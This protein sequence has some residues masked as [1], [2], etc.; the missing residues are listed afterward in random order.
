LLKLK[1]LELFGFKS[2]CDRQQLQFGGGGVSA[3]VGPNGCGKSNISDSIS[4]V[5][6]ERSAKSLRGARMGD[7]IFNGSRDRKPSGF[8]AVSLTLLDPDG[9]L[10]SADLNGLAHV[11]NGHG[12]NGSSSSL[13]TEI[14]VTR[15]L[16]NSGESI[17]LLNGKTC[18]LRDIQ[19]LFMGTG[20]GPEHYAIIEQGRVGQILGSRPAERR[21]VI[22][23]AAGITKFKTKKRLAE[24]KLE[25]AR[26]NLHRVND[27]LQE[28]IRQVGSLKR[29]AAK[30]RRYEELRKQWTENLALLLAS[31]YREMNR[32]VEEATGEMTRTDEEFRE[33]AARVAELETSA[34]ENRRQEQVHEQSLEQR[35]AELSEVTMEIERLRS[36]VEQQTRTAGETSV[37]THQAEAEVVQLS[38]RMTALEEELVREQAALDSVSGQAA[39]VRRQLA[40]KTAELEQRMASIRSDEQRQEG[41]RHQVLRLLG[42]LSSLKNELAKMDEFLAGNERHL[43]RVQEEA[44]SAEQELSE[45]TRGHG[46]LEGQVEEQQQKLDAL[47]EQRRLTQQE[48]SG[49]KQEAE[50]RR[51][52]AEKLRHDLSRLRARRESLDEILSHHAYTTETVKNLFASIQSR[53]VSGFEP[54]GILADFVEVDSAFE[55]MSEDFLRE[56][57]EFVV[58]K[59]W[60][61]AQQGLQLLYGEIQGCATFLV[62]PESPVPPE[63]AVLGPETGVVGRLSDHIRLTN[64]LS[65]SASTLLPRLRSCYL[66]EEETAAKRLGVQYPDLYFLLPNGQCYHGYTVSGGKKGTAG[67]LALKREL[68]ELTPRLAAMEEQLAEAST[69]AEQDQQQI[70]AST[71]QLESLQAEIQ[72]AE[73]GI[74]GVEHQLRQLKDQTERAQRRLS[75]SQSDMERLRR[76]AEQTTEQ[77]DRNR[78]AINERE[79]QRLAVEESLSQL[80]Q[81]LQQSHTESSL[82]SEEQTRLR[83]EAAALEERHKAAEAS[84]ARVRSQAAELGE[85]RRHILAQIESW[86]AECKRLLA[87]NQ[88]LELRI[89]EQTTRRT[90][91]QE[92]VTQLSGDLQHAREQAAAI[93]EEVKDKR[94]SLETVRERRSAIELALVELR[95]DV[96]HL[97]ETCRRDLARPLASLDAEFTE[98]LTAERLAEAEERHQELSSK[99]EGLGPVNVLALEEFEE[100]QQR[101]EFLDTQRTDLIDSI[102]DTQKVIQEIEVVSRKQFQE[103]F[104]EINKNFRQIF[105]SLFGGGVGEM[106]LIEADDPSEAGV[107][108]VASPPGKRLQNIAL[109]SGGEKSLTALGLLMATFRY[110]P[111]PF[112][113]LD[114]VDAALD[115]ANLIRFRRLVQEMSDQTQ[116]ILITHSKATMEIAQTLY[117][118]TMQEPGV[119]KLVS[120]RMSDQ[121]QP[122][123][124]SEK[125]RP[126]EEAEEVEEGETVPVGA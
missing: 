42:E 24:L 52:E 83:T 8:A 17:Y 49:R 59:N 88:N 97:D 32:R 26:Q 111:S 21:A 114:E 93:D 122:R 108:I 71:Q 56:E 61:E 105:V 74:L 12:S 58:V 18:R 120:V 90:E 43:A 87:D 101:M 92:Q 85:R 16:F 2:F 91:L 65:G 46:D 22:E 75:V 109:L 31:R 81:A 11:V 7:V 37:R 77:R 106:R 116:F 5:L 53:P 51:V 99:I 107:E 104:D 82:L 50:R 100:A 117:G 47:T 34:A 115:E 66:V 27:I 1:K 78:V 55:R 64:G 48:I 102:H 6:G 84:L 112:C 86:N 89:E 15:K 62:H 124:K 10:E 3:I 13:P 45:L 4:W 19:E 60:R 125:S 95:S 103:A 38:E 118:V 41:L 123:P 79:T 33:L 57:L 63:P 20:L 9:Y 28:V 113:I 119:S 30:A 67:P 98:D 36:R 73:K 39:E 68:R 121:D 54:V 76:E 69:A 40:E 25:S 110:R 23:E 72:T 14:T 94:V 29:Q 80:R 96:K 70:A 35:R 126:A 44:S